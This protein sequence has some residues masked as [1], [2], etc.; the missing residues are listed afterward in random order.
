MFVSNRHDPNV[1]RAVLRLL[2]QGKA[3]L[4][5]VAEIAGLSRQIVR[6][7]AKAAGIDWKAARKAHLAFM[8][9]KEVNR[10]PERLG[11]ATGQRFVEPRPH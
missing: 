3:S 7:W 10:G 8:W 1:R 5:E 2:S 6:Y 4:A 11:Q 9:R